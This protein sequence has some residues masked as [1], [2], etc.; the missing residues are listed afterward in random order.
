MPS[1]TYTQDVES[2]VDLGVQT[3]PQESITIT[4]LQENAGQ[5]CFLC[6]ESHNQGQYA[7][8]VPCQRPTNDG[9]ENKRRRGRNDNS[10]RN[11]VCDSDEEI[12]RRLIDNC[13]QHLGWWKRWLPYYGITEVLEVNV[14]LNTL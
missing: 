11:S 13:Y 7:I 12:Y 1:P 5:G 3:D 14:S 8:L 9:R 2:Q 4:S 6:L 10:N